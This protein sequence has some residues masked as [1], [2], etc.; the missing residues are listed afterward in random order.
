[1]T[2]PTG[3]GPLRK[4]AKEV[5]L[6]TRGE[7]W[8]GGY[9]KARWPEAEFPIGNLLGSN[10]YWTLSPEVEFD[11]LKL[12][13][14]VEW[15]RRSDFYNTHRVL[16]FIDGKLVYPGGRYANRWRP[17]NLFWSTWSTHV[18]EQE[19]AEGG[20]DSRVPSNLRA[21]LIETA[22]LQRLGTGEHIDGER[23]EAE[24]EAA[25][26]VDAAVRRAAGRVAQ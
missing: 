23:L 18:I 8:R 11:G 9:G 24:L 3:P 4:L 2:I 26:E 21:S 20:K 15:T 22:R 16:V 6:A 25:A 1:M 13:V 10:D 19:V 12:C 17:W 14:A 7:V 5:Y